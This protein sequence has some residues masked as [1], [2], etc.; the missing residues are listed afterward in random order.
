MTSELNIERIQGFEQRDQLG[1]LGVK[2]L[3]L[4]LTFGKSQRWG[5][6]SAT[7]GTD[8][9]DH[10]RHLSTSAIGLAVR[11]HLHD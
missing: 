3:S 11:V 5:R 6:R 9:L 7:G 2:D 10:T 4:S 1:I 8:R